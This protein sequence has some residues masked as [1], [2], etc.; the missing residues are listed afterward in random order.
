MQWNGTLCLEVARC[1]PSECNTDDILGNHLTVDDIDRNNY[2]NG[3]QIRVSCD[4][5]YEFED[6]Q[7]SINLQCQNGKWHSTSGERIPKCLKYFHCSTQIM[8]NVRLSGDKTRQNADR[9]FTIEHDSSAR[10]VTI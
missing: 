3:D 2:I 1:F 7:E 6:D 9:T 8:T 10:Y 5:G 4:N